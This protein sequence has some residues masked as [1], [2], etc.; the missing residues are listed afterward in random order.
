MQVIDRQRNRQGIIAP[1]FP[2]RA[3][4]IAFFADANYFPYTAVAVQS[5]V[6]TSSQEN[7][8]DI[9]VFTEA[10]LPRLTQ[11]RFLMLGTRHPNISLRLVCLEDSDLASVRTLYHGPLSAMTYGRILLPVLLPSYQRAIYLDAD[12]VVRE[13]LARFFAIDLANNLIG[14]VKDEGVVR[15]SV[16]AR[17]R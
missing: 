11:E 9:L 10:E 2:D 16:P 4:P 8:Y 13:D 12:I 3:V 7:C 15:V 14:A 5:I 1:A 17:W 6:E